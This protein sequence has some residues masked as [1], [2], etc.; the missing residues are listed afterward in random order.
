VGGDS[1]KGGPDSAKLP[2][3]SANLIASL[4]SVNFP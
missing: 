3:Y 2:H 1:A 4:N